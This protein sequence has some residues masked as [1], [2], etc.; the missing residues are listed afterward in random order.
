MKTP[1]FLTALIADVVKAARKA[2]DGLL[3]RAP[4][5]APGWVRVTPPEAALRRSRAYWANRPGYGRRR[6][7]RLRGGC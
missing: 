6:T 5:P 7:P 1:S 4:T 2:L 3:G